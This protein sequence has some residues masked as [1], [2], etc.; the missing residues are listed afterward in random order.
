MSKLDIMIDTC[1][2]RIQT[3]KLCTLLIEPDWFAYISQWVNVPPNYPPIIANLGKKKHCGVRHR[4][5]SQNVPCAT[6]VRPRLSLAFV[7]RQKPVKTDVTR[8]HGDRGF[9]M[10]TGARDA[11]KKGDHRGNGP[12]V[13]ADRAGRRARKGGFDNFL[14]FAPRQHMPLNSRGLRRYKVYKDLRPPCTYVEVRIHI[15]VP[16]GG[17]GSLHAARGRA[18]P[19]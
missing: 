13:G 10:E 8:E 2:F 17:G 16:R 9:T 14:Q 12:D 5:L 1:S 7:P 18:A 11:S 3:S 4:A 6:A 19:Q 15:H